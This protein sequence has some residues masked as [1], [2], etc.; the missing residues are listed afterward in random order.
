MKEVLKELDG[1]LERIKGGYYDPFDDLNLQ[2]SD[3][4]IDDIINHDSTENGMCVY[5]CI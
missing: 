3:I 5:I 2:T 1:M 4:V